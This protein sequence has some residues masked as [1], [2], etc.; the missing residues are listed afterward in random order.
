MIRT[1]KAGRRFLVIF[2]FACMP[3]LGVITWIAL[4]NWG[5]FPIEMYLIVGGI[6]LGMTA[7]VKGMRIVVTHDGILY[8]PGL[9]FTKQVRFG[10]IAFS[11]TAPSDPLFLRVFVHG[12]RVWPAMTIR[13][14]PF[15]TKD[16]EWLVSVPQLRVT[17]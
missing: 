13:L 16:V 4:S 15:S 14:L 7:V 8:K 11:R 17:R 1:L 10:D 9:G 5:R 12:R 3:Y 2:A 6:F